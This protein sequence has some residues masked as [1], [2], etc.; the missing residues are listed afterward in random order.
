M[1]KISKGLSPT[2]MV[3]MIMMEILQI[4]QKNRIT[5]V[6]KQ[7]HH[8]YGL[9]YI[10]W[11]GP[12]IWDLIPKEV[13]KVNS[14][15][16]FKLKIKEFCFNDCSCSLCKD[17]ISGGGFINQRACIGAFKCICFWIILVCK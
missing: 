13:K 17:Y 6:T 2:F 15:D 11:L 3:E 7:R 1:C 14:L 5:D 8:R 10:R 4:L 16:I 12:N 9:K